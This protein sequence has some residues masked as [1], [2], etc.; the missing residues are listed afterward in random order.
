[1]SSVLTW[2][3]IVAIKNITP[4][5]RSEFVYLGAH[6]TADE[7]MPGVWSRAEDMSL[8]WP[9]RSYDGR[10][11]D[12]LA[13]S[14]PTNIQL[15]DR[16]YGKVVALVQQGRHFTHLGIVRSKKSVQVTDPTEQ[17][18]HFVW[19]EILAINPEGFQVD[20]PGV[21]VNALPFYNQGGHFTRIDRVSGLSPV[22]RTQLRQDI[23]LGFGPIATPGPAITAD[24]KAF[25]P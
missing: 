22:Q 8:S 4:Q 10:V 20:V 17:Y 1:M 13:V 14:S 18:Q 21:A 3:D 11:G 6:N 7:P 9:A 25:R 23:W 12:F 5:A 16:L 2:K 15:A 24:R 19:V